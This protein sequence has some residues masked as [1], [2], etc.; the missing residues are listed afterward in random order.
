MSDERNVTAEAD[1]IRRQFRRLGID[2]TGVDFQAL[3]RAQLDESRRVPGWRAP[4]APNNDWYEVERDSSGATC[5]RSPSRSLLV[6][7][8]C[9]VESD[10]RAWL[11][12][13]VS[14]KSSPRRL[15]THGEMSLVKQTF[16]GDRYA[17]SVHP[18]RRLHVN[19]AEA[20]HLWALLDKSAA[21]PIPEFSKGGS[22]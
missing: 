9:S 18:P 19:I 2:A 8:S 17:Y 16:L 15:P 20:L 21:P 22:I 6:I 13:S 3:A 7:M 5:Y 4:D 10:G 1:G 12:V 11:H 14:S